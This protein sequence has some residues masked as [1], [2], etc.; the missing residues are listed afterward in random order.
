LLGAAQYLAFGS[1]VTILF[2]IAA[3]QIL[4]ALALAALLVSGTPL[5]LPRIW[6]PLGLFL[7]VTLVSL[8]FSGDIAAGL[9]QVRKMYVYS[10]LLLAC[11]LFRGMRMVRWLFL[12]WAGVGALVAARGLAQ[13]AGKVSEAAALGR[14]FYDYY[15]PER[16]TGF[17]SHWMTFGGEQM[18]VLL[19]LLAYLFWSPAARRRGLWFSILCLAALCAGLLLGF[20]RSIW[21]ATAVA[22]LYLVWFWKRPL[23]AAAPLA[24]LIGFFLA[25]DSLRARVS[26]ISR[27]GDYQ[28]RLVTWRT[29]LR[30]IEAHPLLGLGP[31]QVSIQ[32]QRYLPPDA[33]RPLPSG[34]YG[35]MHNIYLQYAAERGVAATVILLWMLFLMIFDFA[36]ALRRLPAGRDDR[37]F[38]LH[39]AIAVIIA[40]MVAGFFEHNLGDSE[41]LTMFLVVAGCGYA[42]AEKEPDVA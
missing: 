32:F 30:M 39:G 16:I 41:I 5:R 19:M 40:L 6:I 8:A 28:F 12:A 13:F 36:K 17:M 27:P 1:A 33:P 15:E 2:S 26:S 29:G 20:T 7:L 18:I 10:M 24:L 4:M 38:V 35:H 25:P 22:S 37:R 31:E 3:S 11:S 14:R 42:A 21:L 9:P 34:W 23:V